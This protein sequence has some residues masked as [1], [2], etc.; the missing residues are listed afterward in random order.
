MSTTT[1]TTNIPAAPN[2]SRRWR[3]TLQ[4]PK[5][6]TMAPLLNRDASA[7]MTDEECD[8]WAASQPWPSGWTVIGAI[9]ASAGG[10]GQILP[11]D[12]RTVI[13]TLVPTT[14]TND[15]QV[16]ADL[17][18]Y[19]AAQLVGMRTNL[20]DYISVV[21]GMGQYAVQR[22]DP[23][24]RPIGLEPVKKPDGIAAEID[25]IISIAHRRGIGY[26]WA[27]PDTGWAENAADDEACGDDK[28]REKSVVAIQQWIK[29]THP[30]ILL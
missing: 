20:D 15:W 8:A 11:T 28:R 16:R 10:R 17:G 23:D 24:G 4:H 6:E 27:R 26:M 21:A 3:V 2:T 7:Q 19:A 5:S 18:V 1:T 12:R 13:V 9:Q 25:T 29:S 14:W 22:H 30:E